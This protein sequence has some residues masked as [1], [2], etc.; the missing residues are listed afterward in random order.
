MIFN[1]NHQYQFIEDNI[2]LTNGR[3][4]WIKKAYVW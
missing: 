4:N 3:Y 2:G 1:F